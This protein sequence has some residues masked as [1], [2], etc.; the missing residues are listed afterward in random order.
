MLHFLPL[1]LHLGSQGASPQVAPWGEYLV[2]PAGGLRLWSMDTEYPL[3]CALGANPNSS[4][5]VQFLL[6]ILLGI[7]LQ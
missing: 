3:T 6:S 2:T 7:N 5:T 1:G 4:I